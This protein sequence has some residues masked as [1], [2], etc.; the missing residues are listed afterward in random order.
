MKTRTKRTLIIVGIFI[1]A[2]FA[3]CGLGGNWIYSSLMASASRL[4]I[5]E[6]AAEANGILVDPP[7]KPFPSPA[8][9]AAMIYV[10]MTEP[11]LAARDQVS[12][13]RF[14]SYLAGTAGDDE[15]AVENA[16]RKLIEL[17]GEVVRRPECRWTLDYPDSYLTT[18]P[19]L[20]AVQVAA[21]LRL[22]SGLR[23][24][25][26]GG[27][28]QAAKD[29]LKM[30]KDL[31]EIPDM[32]AATVAA[33]LNQSV[34]DFLAQQ[35]VGDRT[36]APTILDLLSAH[37]SVDPRTGWKGMARQQYLFWSEFEDQPA[38]IRKPF[39]DF[40]RDEVVLVNAELAQI[41]H[42]W[43]GVLA[44]PNEV[45]GA[46]CIRFERQVADL[47]KANGPAVLIIKRMFS[48]PAMQPENRTLVFVREA[49]GRGMLSEACRYIIHQVQEPGSRYE[50]TGKSPLTGQPFQIVKTDQGFTVA[51]PGPGDKEVPAILDRTSVALRIE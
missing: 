36:L 27:A 22:R 4:D 14:A 12:E 3:V 2:L 37:P 20:N 45:L 44:N 47:D 40:P 23:G 33:R 25:L 42:F 35:L 21:H 26:P 39:E 28:M 8:D 13:S 6:R 31:A 41:L 34:D 16:Y 9:N 17:T 32:G 1:V 48:A 43:N 19:F 30:A 18:Y 50:P 11:W 7:A 51:S 5:E 10:Q 29:V 46:A 49:E 24:R 38:D 15:I